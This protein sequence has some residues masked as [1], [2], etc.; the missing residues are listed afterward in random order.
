MILV[1]F[2]SHKD[3][4]QL[5][6]IV[7]NEITNILIW[8]KANKLSMNLSKTHFMFFHPRQKLLSFYY[9]LVYP[10]LTDC[11]VAWSA[12]HCSN[13]N[14]TCL[15]QKRIVQLI[16]KAGYLSDTAPLCCQLRLLHIF[17]INSFSIPIFKCSYHHILLPV[18]Y[19]CF[20]FSRMVNDSI[21]TVLE[22]PF[23]IDHIFVELI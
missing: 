8:L 19:Q 15:L 23:N 1:F 5:I 14:C 22:L 7:T 2:F 9:S 18:T 11:N 12:T 6:S 13:L 3:H 17:S 10:Y 16:A 21:N 4:N 20:F